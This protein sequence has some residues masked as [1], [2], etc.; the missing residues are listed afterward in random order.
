MRLYDV[1]SLERERGTLNT[2]MRLR[3]VTSLDALSS[4]S[5]AFSCLLNR[6]LAFKQVD[7]FS[8]V[9]SFETTSRLSGSLEQEKVPPILSFTADA[10]LKAS[11]SGVHPSSVSEIKGVPLENT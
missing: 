8:L 2:S 9:D 1:A 7:R 5:S 3:D 6:L 10:N 11:S 4:R